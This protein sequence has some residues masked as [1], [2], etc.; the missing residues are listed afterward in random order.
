M[1]YFKSLVANG[2]HHPLK[3][4]TCLKKRL[5]F[6]PLFLLIGYYVS[7]QLETAHLKRCYLIEE[8]F[9]GQLSARES[10]PDKRGNLSPF[11]LEAKK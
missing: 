5:K 2:L 4:P 8:F 6:L 1:M 11:I 3:K 7:W 9:C 10:K